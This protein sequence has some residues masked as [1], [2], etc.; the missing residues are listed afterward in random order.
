M[1]FP[2]NAVLMADDDDDDDD[3][4]TVCHDYDLLY[5]HVP[6]VAVERLNSQLRTEKVVG[7]NLWPRYYM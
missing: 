6:N 3:S 1:P 7:S 2:Y 5:K 4:N